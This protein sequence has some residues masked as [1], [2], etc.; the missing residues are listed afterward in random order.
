MQYVFNKSLLCCFLFTVVT[1]ALFA[2]TEQAPIPSVYGNL[3]Y[4]KSGNL[5]GKQTDGSSVTLFRKP[6]WYTLSGVTPEV[7]GEKDGLR[8]LFSA[9]RLRGGTLVYGLIPYGQHN[10]PAAV[11]RFQT[12][13][14][15]HG[16]SLLPVR[17]D[18]NEGYDHTGWRISG[19]GVVGYRLIDSN[20]VM[21]HEGKVAFTADA[22]R[23]YPHPG[24][25]RGP[26]VSCQTDSSVTVWYETSEPVLTQIDLDADTLDF[27]GTIP[28]KRHEYTLRG[29]RSDTEYRYTVRCGDLE[30]SYH[31]RTAPAPGASTPF[32]FAYASDSRSGYGGGERNMYG[33][34][35][36]IMGRIGALALH[37]GAAFV[38]FTGDQSDG[39]V[40]DPDEWRLQAANWIQAVEP[41][42]HYVPF[43]VGM[44]NHEALGWAST[45]RNWGAIDGFPFET[46]SAEALF[47]ELFVEPINGPD[48]EDG[49][50]YDPNPDTPGDFPTYR[51][52]TYAYTFGNTAMIVLNSDYWFAPLLRSLR[53]IGGNLHGY[54]MDRQMEW[55]AQTLQAFENDHNIDHVFLTI[56]TPPFPNGG[57]RGDCMWYNGDNSNRPWVAGQPV[58]K[59][60]I[61]R[62][63]EFLDLC[64]NQ[65]SKV[66]AFLCGDEH[67]YNRMRIDDQTPRY[68]EDW[69]KVRLP[70]RRTVWQVINGAAG[71]PF[72]GK[73]ELPWSAGVEGFTVQNA[74]CFFE[75]SGKA[76][77]LRVVNPDTLE[78]ID[79]VDLR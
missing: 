51:E 42:W 50:V 34:N 21:I 35:S 2:Q 1:S 28:V 9:E 14:D 12:S 10:Y 66:V 27:T 57:H 77:K 76:V 24:I 49:A 53:P 32:V 23:F 54:I 75:V 62:R 64:V 46:Y 39:Y 3:S 25:L 6:A 20:G 44:G 11:L 47:G 29:L 16:E 8:L 13:I 33:T 63:D 17:K 45:A 19:R 68:P 36:Q 59:G 15:D 7:R 38:Q 37:E 71:A 67:N 65:S 40:S 70:L 52:N 18:L 78:E 55:L 72:Y 74:L 4:N 22:S 30:Q 69:D 31:F 61:E 48:S 58:E 26:F 56:H 43:H 73:Q 60:I 5:Q 79:R 41:Y